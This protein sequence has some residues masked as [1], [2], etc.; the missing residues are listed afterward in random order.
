MFD[1]GMGKNKVLPLF[2]CQ[3]LLLNE[4]LSRIALQGSG[5][6]L[7]PLLHVL[8]QDAHGDFLDAGR[9]NVNPHGTGHAREFL[10]CGQV[11]L[12][13]ALSNHARLALA[14]DHAQEKKRLVNPFGQNIGVVLMAARDDQ[15]QRRLRRQRSLQ[16]FAPVSDPQMDP[17]GEMFR[18]GQF[19]PVISNF[20]S[21]KKS[22]GLLLPLNA[23]IILPPESSV[24]L[25]QARVRRSFT[26]DCP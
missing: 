4:G 2:P 16:Q 23:T 6:M 17:I 3:N 11:P 21:C 22:T 13:K 7:R 14:A 8:R 1:R 15:A 5:A 24:T 20:A 12:K 25:A 19:R 18:V 26:V 9:A 10:R